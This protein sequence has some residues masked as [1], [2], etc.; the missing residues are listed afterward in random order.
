[1]AAGA[2]QH[3]RPENET[4][5]VVKVRMHDAFVVRFAV[6]DRQRRLLRV[7]AGDELRRGVEG[8]EAAVAGLQPIQVDQPGI[9]RHVPAAVG[10]GRVNGDRA[11]AIDHSGRTAA[12]Q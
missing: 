12:R 10:P 11:F 6:D 2:A 5:R 1:M 9:V 7:F 3:I 8:L 4:N